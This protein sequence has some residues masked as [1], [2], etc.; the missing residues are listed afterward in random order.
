M[1]IVFNC[2]N[3]NS[4]V[5]SLRSRWYRCPTCDEL[6]NPVAAD[7]L[8]GRPSLDAL[9]QKL[10]S[11]PGLGNPVIADLDRGGPSLDALIEGLQR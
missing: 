1:T 8:A 3:C 7:I 11:S 6:T 4:E 9:I 10:E 5:R 2:P